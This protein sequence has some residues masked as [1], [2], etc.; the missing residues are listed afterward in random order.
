MRVDVIVVVVMCDLVQVTEDSGIQLD[1]RY[2][3]SNNNWSAPL[4]SQVS[5]PPLCVV[6]TDGL[7]D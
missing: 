4:Y 3:T 6:R 5:R 7:I 2:A 1:L